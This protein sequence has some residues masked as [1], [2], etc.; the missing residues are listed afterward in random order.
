MVAWAEPYQRQTRRLQQHLA[1]QAASVPV[2]HVAVMHGL[3]WSTVR[4]AEGAAL[5][6]WDA[7]RTKPPLKQVGLDENGSVVGINSNMTSS[8]W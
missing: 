7:T 3:S 5:A 6:R 2:M 1:L 4:R 8:L